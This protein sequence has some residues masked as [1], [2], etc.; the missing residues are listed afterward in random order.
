MG[1]FYNPS[2]VLDG[3][4]LML[5][6]ANV[7]SYPGSGT[8]TYNLINSAS[9]N[10]NSVTYSSS[11][12]GCYSLSGSNMNGGDLF[13]LRNSIDNLSSLTVSMWVKRSRFITS[14]ETLF[15]L[16]KN[17]G[18]HT[19]QIAFLSNNIYGGGRSNTDSSF[20]GI[21][22]TQIFNIN[23]FY[24]ITLTMNLISKQTRFYVDGVLIPVTGTTNYATTFFGPG[25]VGPSTNRIGDEVQAGVAPF[26]GLISQVLVYNRELNPDEI[27]KN[28]NATKGRFISKNFITSDNLV[29]SNDV[30]DPLSYPGTG[31]TWYNGV[32]V[33]NHSTMTNV[34]YNS[35]GYM[36]YNGTAYTY[37]DIGNLNVRLEGPYSINVWTYWN[38]SGTDIIDIGSGN[39]LHQLGVLGGLTLWKFGG[40]PLATTT[41]DT[42]KWMNVAYTI[43]NSYLKLY[44]NGQLVF[45]NTVAGLSG[46]CDQLWTGTF[47]PL[48]GG[49][50]NGRISNFQ[51]YNR[52]LS[53]SE[54]QENYTKTKARYYDIP[55]ITLPGLAV[56]YD[57]GYVNSYP[58]SGNS[59]FDISGNGIT[60]TLTNGPVFVNSSDSPSIQFDATNDSVTFGTSSV[61]K[62]TTLSLGCIFKI[63]AAPTTH[64]IAGK[65][66]TGSGAA[67]YALV[68]QSNSL[69][70]RLE[71]GGNI[72][73]AS[74]PFVN[75]NTY[76]YAM[77]TADGNTLRLYIN[78]VLV[79][80]TAYSGS[81]V[82]SDSFPLLMGYYASAF[83]SPMNVGA[84]Q[85]YSRPLSAQEVLRNYNAYR[86]R[87][88]L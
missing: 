86:G 84:M 39:N 33:T 62:P 49:K 65:Q 28:Y 31:N 3:L 88:G 75:Q 13:N 70:F 41:M 8:L 38:G 6:P 87:Y 46:L 24:H 18:T 52:V 16:V 23:K 61:V 34:V 50:Y 15:A 20:Q 21:Q 2:V 12:S 25:A 83:A 76:I 29:V 47:T 59:W 85:L 78:G 9:I 37:A 17:N 27:F 63:N 82:Y 40:T 54:I 32:G 26:H 58:G 66:G 81:I 30:T 7:K 11:F 68:I 60:G 56:A 35:S 22:S 69:R 79:S 64:I 4:L 57:A 73:D 19:V 53:A 71:I 74:Y 77:G 80:S 42:G 14:T 72:Y 51:V 55:D 1:L 67:S 36:D 43:E 44:K 45:S 5:D 10:M 48:Y